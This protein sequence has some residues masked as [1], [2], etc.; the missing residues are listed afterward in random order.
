MNIPLNNKSLCP[1]S[2]RPF[3]I[4]DNPTDYPNH[5]EASY[6]FRPS[7]VKRKR[8]KC[9]R[10]GRRVMSSVSTCRDGCCVTH[11]L[12]AHKPRRWWKRLRKKK[13]RRSDRAFRRQRR[14]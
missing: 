11:Y 7:G 1:G 13:P 9:P 3:L 10:C 2:R 6:G 4:E 14:I 5:L 8:L 12:P